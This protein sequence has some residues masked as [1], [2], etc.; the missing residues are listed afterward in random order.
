LAQPIIASLAHIHTPRWP[1]G[2][3]SMETQSTATTTPPCRSPTAA[4]PSHPLPPPSL[5]S[6]TPPETSA[7]VPSRSAADQA[8]LHQL[9]A[10]KPMKTAAAEDTMATPRHQLGDAIKT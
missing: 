3:Q 5:L 10:R 9:A 7:A 2:W 6:P 4:P 8:V 1:D